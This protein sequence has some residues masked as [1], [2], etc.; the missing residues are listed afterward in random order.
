MFEFEIHRFLCYYHNHSHCTRLSGWWVQESTKYA[1][2]CETAH[3]ILKLQSHNG[4]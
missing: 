3:I 2:R 4:A 1:V